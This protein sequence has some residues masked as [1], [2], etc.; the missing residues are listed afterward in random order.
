MAHGQSIG[1]VI[2]VT[3]VMLHSNECIVASKKLKSLRI[4][5]KRVVRLKVRIMPFPHYFSHR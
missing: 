2:D 5:V 4:I 3:Y 1:H